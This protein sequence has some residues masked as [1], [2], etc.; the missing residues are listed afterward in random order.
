MTGD[1]RERPVREEAVPWLAAAVEMLKESLG[2]AVRAPASI[3]NRVF[4]FFLL[5]GFCFLSVLVRER[6]EEGSFF[7]RVS[8]MEKRRNDNSGSDGEIMYK[9]GP[10]GK[11]VLLRFDQRKEGNKSSQKI[12]NALFVFL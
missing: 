1:L 11:N 6:K 12:T 2:L 3:S 7:S 10:A 4:F 9:N 8:T 5:S